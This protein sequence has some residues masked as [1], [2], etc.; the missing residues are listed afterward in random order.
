MGRCFLTHL[1]D[2]GKIFRM[3]Q[4]LL[5]HTLIITAMIYTHVIIEGGLAIVHIPHFEKSAKH[6]KQRCLNTK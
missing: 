5:G 1:L 6:Y 3:T 4:V 2:C